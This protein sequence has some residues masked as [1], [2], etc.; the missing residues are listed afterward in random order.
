MSGAREIQDRAAEWLLKSEEPD[1]TDQDQSLL[2][3]WLA[4]SDAHKA[5][6]WRLEHGWRG[7]DRVRAL[8]PRTGAEPRRLDWLRHWQPFAA[9]ASI[10]IV[11]AAFAAV[12][13]HPWAGS[14]VTAPPATFQTAIGGHKTVSLP[15]GS[16]V[17]LNTATLIRAALDDRQ[18]TVWLDRGEAYFEVTKNPERPFVVMAGPRKVTVLGT[19]FLVRRNGP[20]VVVSVVEGRVRVDEVGPS[21]NKRSTTITTGNVALGEGSMTLV[22]ASS[23]EQV[24]EQLAWRMGTL[25]FDSTSLSNAAA[26]FNRYN[27]KQLVIEDPKARDIRI[28]GSFDAKNVDAFARLLKDAYGLKVRSDQDKIFVTG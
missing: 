23:S 4:Q 10:I 21:A 7:A 15:D 13:L 14:D 16:R 9:A 8:G 20:Q 17:E 19:K 26:E 18:R 25:F 22:K 6:Y 24:Q 27:R 3:Q 2:D 1:W 5:A 11:F 28:G 12:G